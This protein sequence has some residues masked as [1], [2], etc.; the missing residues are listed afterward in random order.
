MKREPQEKAADISAANAMLSE[1]YFVLGKVSHAHGRGSSFGYPTANIPYDE[2]R[3]YPAPGVY[4]T[5]LTVDGQTYLGGTNIGSKPTFGD[6]AP[7]V[8][9]FILDFC[10]DIYGRDVKL[11]F[12]KRL[13]GIE[14]FGSAEALAAQLGRDKENIRALFAEEYQ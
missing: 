6:T 8:E 9:T 3:L 4:A 12:F 5:K 7:S 2:T 11:A 1:P 14:D 10:G 13:R